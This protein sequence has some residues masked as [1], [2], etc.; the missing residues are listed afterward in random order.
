MPIWIKLILMLWVVTFVQM[1][2]LRMWM[3]LDSNIER[4][5]RRDY[6]MW[7]VFP[8]FCLIASTVSIIPL[9]AWLI[10]FR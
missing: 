5:A 3:S 10:F 9:F 4:I 8:G 7:T 2:Y 1:I 6:P